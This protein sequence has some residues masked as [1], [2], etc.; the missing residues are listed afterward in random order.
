MAKSAMRL[1]FKE[2]LGLVR[3]GDRVKYMAYAGR[4]SKGPEYREAEGKVNPLLIF[5]EHMVINVGGRHGT[6]AVVNEEN[7][8]AVLLPRGES[9]ESRRKA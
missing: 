2:I 6:P 4:G 3:G 1:P 9:W 8:V 7:F 5:P